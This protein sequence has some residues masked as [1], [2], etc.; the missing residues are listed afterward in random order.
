MAAGPGEGTGGAEKNARGEGRGGGG[1]FRGGTTERGSPRR[2]GCAF[3]S[4]QM[5]RSGDGPVR[6]GELRRGARC[7]EGEVREGGMGAEH[8]A[9]PATPRRAFRPSSMPI[10][11]QQLAGP[12]GRRFWM[13]TL[14]Y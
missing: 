1:G 13:I 4:A 5:G 9:G 12:A 6:G 3:A 2:P 11:R 14:S 10:V 8:A 7:A